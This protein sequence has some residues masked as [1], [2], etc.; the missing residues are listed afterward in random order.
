[1]TA[2][3]WR[4]KHPDEKG[5]IRDAADLGQLIV[6]ANLEMLNAEYIKEGFPQSERL[7]RLRSTA[8]A[9]LKSVTN[10]ASTKRL[11]QRLGK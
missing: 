4:D 5:N 2:K 8:V 9:Q 1:M 11:G 10:A 7:Q 6:L 3:E